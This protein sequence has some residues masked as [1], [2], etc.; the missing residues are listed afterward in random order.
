MAADDT[1]AFSEEIPEGPLMLDFDKGKL[2]RVLYNLLSNAFK[3]NRK[4]G[5]VEVILHQE[6][7]EAVIQVKD[8]GIGI[9]DK[10]KGRIFERFFQKQPSGSSLTGNGIGLHIVHEYVSL[11]GGTVS[12][13]D[14]EPSGTVFTVRI[15]IRETMKGHSSPEKSL[16]AM[17]GSGK[18]S[19]LVVEDNAPFRKFLLNY[20]S[21]KY[22]AV[23][24]E[25]GRN[26]LDLMAEYPFDVIVSDILMPVMDGLELC[27]TVKNDI[28]HSH[29]PI[30]L[31][32]ALQ[33]QETIKKGLTEGA[34]EYITKPFDIDILDI[35]LE[36]I[37]NW[38]RENHD[39]FGTTA[40]PASD[41]TVSKLDEKLM[42][43]AQEV[44]QQ[45]L[46][47]SDF[48]VEELSREI[49]LSR[50]GLYK[51]L[52]FITG[53]SPIEFIRIIRLRKGKDMLEEGETSVSQIAWSVGFSPKQ[54]SKY[55]KEEY[56]CLPSDYVKH[57]KR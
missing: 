31:L 52:T 26:A 29:I 19:V 12:A 16:D 37:L 46:S 30:I 55:F 47:D 18:P 36:K 17:T 24:A 7:E 11:H 49:G 4:G 42:E 51:K 3:Y 39:K 40:L 57:L 53:R 43:K 13:T 41:I 10:D 48:S 1:V 20:L 56:G 14:N 9:S 6:N 34:D 5:K 23:G 32:S 21:A 25:N 22:D 44:I 27:R 45:H 33:D 15:P 2:Q 50:S 35:K 28:R 54:F 38:T 8:T